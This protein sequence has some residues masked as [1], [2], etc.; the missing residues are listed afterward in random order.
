MA[1]VS[2]QLRSRAGSDL[3][4]DAALRE[5]QAL[6][7][8]GLPPHRRL[9]RAHDGRDAVDVSREG[10]SAVGGLDA[11]EL[12]QG[13]G[14]RADRRAARHL[15]RDAGFVS[16]RARRGHR[17][18][19]AL[20]WQQRRRRSARR[21]G[22]VLRRSRS[23]HSRLGRHHH[24][25]CAHRRQRRAGDG[26]L[27]RSRVLPGESREHPRHHPRLRREDG[28]VA[29]A[30]RSGAEGEREVQRNVGRGLRQI[31][32]ECLA[33]GAAVRRLAAWSRLRRN[34]HADQRLLRR[35]PA[36]H[37]RVRHEPPRHRREDRE[38][39]AGSTSS[40]T[41]TCGTTTFRMRRT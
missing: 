12:R 21:A 14:V 29:L 9:H 16:L 8:G 26:A 35:Q 17:A 3:S 4:R 25:V 23:R 27:A 41:T 18:A 30:L 15:R 2:R 11:E 36:G 33:V 5:R 39:S 7:S 20:V 28:R 32:G 22:T 34:R 38:R 40:C 37:E 13:R 6:H 10:Q 1:L 31:H 19:V 24:F